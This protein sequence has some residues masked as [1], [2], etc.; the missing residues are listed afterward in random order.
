MIK[1]CVDLSGKSA[2]HKKASGFRFKNRDEK[3]IR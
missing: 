2:Y 1:V 3:G